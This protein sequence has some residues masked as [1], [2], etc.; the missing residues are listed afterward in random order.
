[1]RDATAGLFQIHLA[2]LLFGLA[3]LFGKFLTL[4]AF[5]IVLGRTFFASLTLALA[6]L[7]T[8]RSSRPRS[9]KD[10]ALF[11]VLGGV[12]AL[13]WTTFFHS[14][15]VSTVA[16]GLVTFTTFPLF[17]TLMEPFFFKEALRG[18]D[19]ATAVLVIL[20]IL[21]VIPT[22]DFSH[23]VTQGAFWGMISG[24]TFAILSLINRRYVKIYSPLVIAFYQDLFACLLLLPFFP[25]ESGALSFRDYLLLA[26]LGIFCTALAHAL[27]I[28]S[29]GHIRAQ[30]ASITAC[31]E[32]V[33]GII[34]AFLL[35]GERPGFRT[36]LGGLIILGTAVFAS[37]KRKAGIEDGRFRR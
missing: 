8:G 25:T 14:I 1:M 19:I 23:R 17:V 30:L 11:L 34:L 27:F 22:F 15:Q 37:A 31:L 6:L 28:Q 3:G 26:F 13:H 29:L 32:P 33:Y 36:V 4:S 12:L 10:F 35:L 21:L 24:L 18:V 5:V 16:V 20:G 2:V 9:G 7:V